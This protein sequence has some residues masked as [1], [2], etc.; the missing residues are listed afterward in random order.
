MD[1]VANLEGASSFSRI[2]KTCCEALEIIAATALDQLCQLF[3]AKGQVL[4][5]DLDARGPLFANTTPPIEHSIL[6]RLEARS[7]AGLILPFRPNDITPSST[8]MPRANVINPALPT[9]YGLSHWFQ[10]DEFAAICL[11]AI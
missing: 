2:A 3:G 5:E 11:Q 6:L 9:E 8:R 7:N 1:C 10:R 4:I